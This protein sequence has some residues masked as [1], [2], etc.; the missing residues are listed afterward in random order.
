MVSFAVNH[1]ITT[2]TPP[3]PHQQKAS[4]IIADCSRLQLLQLPQSV[5]PRP[6]AADGCKMLPI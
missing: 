4:E 1:L 3:N 2:A 6:E 5:Q